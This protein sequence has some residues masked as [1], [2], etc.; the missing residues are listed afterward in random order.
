M[1][2][3]VHRGSANGL[4]HGPP[5][6][7]PAIRSSCS[8]ATAKR[9]TVSPRSV[10]GGRLRPR[11]RRPVE[12]VLAACPRRTSCSLSGGQGRT[13]SRAT[14]AA[15]CEPLDHGSVIG[16]RISGS[17]AG[18]ARHRADHSP[19][20]GGVSGSRKGH[21]RVMRV[22]PRAR[23]RHR[24]GAR[25]HRQDSCHSEQTGAAPMSRQQSH[26]RDSHAADVRAMVMGVKAG[27]SIQP[28]HARTGSN[29]GSAATPRPSTSFENS[30]AAHPS[31]IGFTNG[32][33]NERT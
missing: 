29:A 3:G 2:I 6:V 9:S 18:R 4:P 31:I 14:A 24:A 33:M 17:D 25:H 19:V 13:G 1:D 16:H 20:S 15:L 8:I 30:P 22:G 10:R 7:E 21:A 5:G 27:A 11:G 23:S 28:N 32:L 26:V 12:T